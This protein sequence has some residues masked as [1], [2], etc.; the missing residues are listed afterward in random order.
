MQDLRACNCLSHAQK[1]EEKVVHFS[2]FALKMN[3]II[4]IERARG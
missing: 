4:S 2:G 3:H 1:K